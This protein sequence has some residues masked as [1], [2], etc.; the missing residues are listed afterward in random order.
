[1]LHPFGKTDLSNNVTF[2]QL[3]SRSEEDS[4]P[5]FR[6]HYSRTY[7]KGDCLL[8]QSFRL[9]TNVNVLLGTSNVFIKPLNL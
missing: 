2:N 9:S 7:A 6:F 5:P 8:H 4:V 1:M 3:L